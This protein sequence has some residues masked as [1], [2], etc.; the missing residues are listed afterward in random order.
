MIRCRLMGGALLGLAALVVAG[1][2][3]GGEGSGQGSVVGV[4]TDVEGQA[5]VGAA[6]QCY[7][8]LTTSVTNGSFAIDGVP[9]GYRTL[10]ARITIQGHVW[11]GETVVDVSRDT[12]N[13]NINIIVSDER[14]QGSIAGTV[15]D[16]TNYPVRYAKVF[17]VGPKGPWGSTMAVADKYGDYRI[18]HLPSGLTYTVTASAADFV[19]DTKQVAVETDKTAAATFALGTGGG[20]RL[21]APTN[22][23]TQTWTVPDTVSRSDAKAGAVYDWLKSRYRG[24]RGLADRAVAKNVE[25]KGATRYSPVG[26]YVEVD[27]FWDYQTFDQLMGYIIRRGTSQSNLKAVALA[28]DPFAAS[29]FDLDYYLTPDQVY[30]YTVS[31]VDTVSYPANGTEG[32]AS[33]VV[34]AQPYDQ[35]S[36]IGP[37]QGASTS[38]TPTFSW[39]ALPGAVTYEVYLWDRFPDLQNSLDPDGVVPI[40]PVSSTSDANVVDA[41]TTSLRYNGA[42]LV[43]G[44]TYYWLV[45]ARDMHDRSSTTT[46]SAS[47]IRKFTVAD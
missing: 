8:L 47:A 21:A 18:D 36:P 4:V 26:S 37:S 1:C 13:R 11:S 33:S 41:P 35:I 27:L 38:T 42:A 29:F 44:H 32:A 39:S 5:V 12:Q 16:A 20:T 34:Q 17:V 7:G 31:R 30:Y 24:I 28:R 23:G 19:N 25:R 46:Y 9:D 14:Y 10:T 43:P 2:G 45:L 15:V 22:V 3:G 6:L 40:W